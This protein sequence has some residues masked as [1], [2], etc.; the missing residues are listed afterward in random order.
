MKLKTSTN[1]TRFPTPASYQP[2][3]HGT[4]TRTD[5]AE[6]WQPQ[7]TLSAPAER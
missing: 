6:Q 4:A 3:L 2:D 1:P 5:T 7:L